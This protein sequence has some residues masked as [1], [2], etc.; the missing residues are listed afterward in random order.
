MELPDI[1]H[2]VA[3]FD[4]RGRLA[5]AE[6][7]GSGHIHHTLAVTLATGEASRR[8]CLQRVNTHVFRRPDLVQ[9]NIDRVTT[10]LQDKLRIE[11]CPDA[12]RRA[13][14]PV[15]THEGGSLVYIPGGDCW[16]MYDLVEGTCSFDHVRDA[17]QA[18]AAS[19]LF[20]CF[21]RRLSDLPGRLEETIPRFHD[22][23]ARY[24]ALE[25]A[26]KED[27]YGRVAGAARELAFAHERR[28]ILSR[29]LDARDRGSV[30]ERTV[31]NDTKLNNILFD[32]RSGEALCVIDLDTVMPGLSL[33]DF[34][35]MVRIA[36]TRAAEDERDLERVVVERELYEA[37]LRG[38]DDELG[39]VMTPDERALLPFSTVLI[40]LEIGMRFLTDHLTGDLYFRIRRPGQNLDRCRAQF[41]LVEHLERLQPEMERLLDTPR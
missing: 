36:A 8:F 14:T 20:A 1:Q 26:V 31:H 30:P 5:S 33:F 18:Y 41:R 38:Y 13:L 25:Q 7:F 12:H 32:D 16:R 15:P 11:S 24:A 35:D 10:H 21:V 40:T 39:P 6:P 17:G 34:G 27:A 23:P 9:A 19:A 2:I 4:V 37:L 29:L 22:T 3:Q 28:G